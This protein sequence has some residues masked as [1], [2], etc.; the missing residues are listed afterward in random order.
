MVRIT[1]LQNIKRSLGLALTFVAVPVVMS[2]CGCQGGSSGGGSSGS[3]PRGSGG[4]ASGGSST[5]GYIS[6]AATPDA[7]CSTLPDYLEPGQRC[8]DR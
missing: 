7:Q 6:P 8:G 2:A 4:S 1:V 5:G 3:A